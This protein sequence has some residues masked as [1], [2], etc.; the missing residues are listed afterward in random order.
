MFALHPLVV[1]DDAARPCATGESGDA[2]LVNLGDE[3]RVTR[4]IFVRGAVVAYG[5]PGREDLV[6]VVRRDLDTLSVRCGNRCAA[7][8]EGLMAYLEDCRLSGG[9]CQEGGKDDSESHIGG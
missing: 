2:V 7:L 4:R 8:E 9:G 6:I 1:A 3:Q 5:Y